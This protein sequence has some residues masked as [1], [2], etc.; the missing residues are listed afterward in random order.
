MVRV[1]LGRGSW[2]VF[3]TLDEVNLNVIFIRTNKNIEK[4]VGNDAGN[5][6]EKPS[7]YEKPI[8]FIQTS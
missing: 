7:G 8:K 3:L 1:G 6:A 2:L 4:I 5:D